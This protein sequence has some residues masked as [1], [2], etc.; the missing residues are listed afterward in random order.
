LKHRHSV[1][2][3]FQVLGVRVGVFLVALYIGKQVSR[4]MARIVFAKAIILVTSREAKKISSSTGMQL[5]VKT[6]RLLQARISGIPK[7]IKE[8]CFADFKL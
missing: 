1:N 4:T 3:C 2:S 8:Y 7:Q 6:S 5:T